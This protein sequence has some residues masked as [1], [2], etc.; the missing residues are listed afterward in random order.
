[1]SEF[2]RSFEDK[3]RGSRQ[4]IMDR[5]GVYIPF[6]E[7]LKDCWNLGVT[8]LGCG[9]G[10]WLEL[11][12]SLGI[13]CQGVDLDDA[14]LAACKG[15][16]FTVTNMDAIAFLKLLPD[17]SQMAVSAFH[18]VEHI[19][20][21]QLRT[22][23]VEAKRVLVP[24]GLLI[25]E[26]PNPENLIVGTSNFFMDPTHVNPLPP[27]LLQ[28]L[29]DYHGYARSKI[30][31]LQEPTAI[32]DIPAV[33]LTNVLHGVSPDY[34]VVAQTA[35]R[36]DEVP[37]LDSLFAKDFG[38]TLDSLAAAFDA[39][40]D[41]FE[42]K[43]S[44]VASHADEH[45]QKAV[46]ASKTEFEMM[47]LNHKLHFNALH[48]ELKT[49]REEYAKVSAQLASHHQLIQDATVQAS[50]V[51]DRLSSLDSR[52][53]ITRG[54]MHALS[55]ILP[56][57][58]VNAARYIVLQGQLLRRDGIK[59]R[60]KL[61]A[62]KLVF[63]GIRKVGPYKPLRV[64]VV[65]VLKKVGAYEYLRS[66]LVKKAPPVFRS[67]V[68]QTLPINTENLSQHARTVLSKIKFAEKTRDRIE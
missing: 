4:L 40:F 46:Q 8:D 55:V 10:E 62:R 18:L 48:L 29:P 16:G 22:L 41:A 59:T 53:D 6:L 15:R 28:F 45:L 30:V 36:G 31:R 12:T 14:M 20:F 63:F 58:L 54:R 64:A 67:T 65:V 66:K 47:Q 50:A 1:M 19:P 7:A 3:H 23:V 44:S 24:G 34:S 49:L 56:G 32:E 2:Y 11:V 43:V 38:V 57:S 13:R 39:R 35:C 51:E 21:D 60:S 52:M 68:D 42:A 33:T 25:L 26:T 37:D 27:P 9:R 61:M 17:G 5:L